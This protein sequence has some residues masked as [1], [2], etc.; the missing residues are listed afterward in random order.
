MGALLRGQVVDGPP[1]PPF[2]QSFGGRVWVTWRAVAAN[3]LMTERGIHRAIER[4]I[5]PAASRQ[6]SRGALRPARSPWRA[7][8]HRRQLG[9]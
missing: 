1:Q 7:R 3:E 5:A 2:A 8:D 9:S 4:R 6:K